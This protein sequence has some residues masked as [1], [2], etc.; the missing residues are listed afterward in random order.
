MNQKRFV[1]RAAIT[2]GVAAAAVFVA[3]GCKNDGH[4]SLFG[5]DT[6]PP[7]DSNIRSVYLPLFKVN[8]Y[9]TNPY[10]NI[11]VDI[12]EA[13]AREL[14]QRHSP[15][16]VVSDPAGADTELIGTV[17]NIYKNQLNR[18][19]FNLLREFDVMITVEIVWRD[20]RTGKVLTSSR[21]PVAPL[22][23]SPF[24]TTLPAAP[25]PP[26]PTGAIPLTIYGFGRVLP[27]LGESNTT[28]EQA[29]INSL[30]RQI[31]NQ[32]EKPW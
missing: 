31:V 32:M 23:V 22:P 29:A 12:N 15:I 25:P 13:I 4:F 14:N 2:V 7:F 24:D 3:A 20:L 30:A 1:R 26:P 18:N 28:G 9:H 8:A 10:R 16:K 11:D 27:E 17:A 19:Q 5:Y 21:G 6:R